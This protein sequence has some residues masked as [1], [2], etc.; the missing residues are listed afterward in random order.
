MPGDEDPALARGRAFLA[1]VKKRVG[2]VKAL[3]A[4]A[5]RLDLEELFVRG[6][7]MLLEDVDP[8]KPKGEPKK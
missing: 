2:Q 7:G 4:A 5:E 3:G 6:V 8:P 1:S